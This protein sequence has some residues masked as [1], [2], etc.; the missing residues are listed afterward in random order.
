MATN[1]SSLPISSSFQDLVLESG[2]F[3][4]NATGSIITRVNVTASHADTASVLTGAIVSS[5]YS[6]S[7]SQADNAGSASVAVSASF[8]TSASYAV[9]ASVEITKEVSSSFADFAGEAYAVSGSGVV[10]A[11]AS[12]SFAETASL[13]LGSVES[14]SFASS[15]SVATLADSASNATRAVSASQ[16]DSASFATLAGDAEEIVIAVKSSQA[17]TILTGQT[18][19][20]VG[21]TGENVDV[22]TASNDI[23]A[24]MPAIGLAKEDI[25]PGSA[26]TAVIS[27]KILGVDTDG[28]TP[29]EVVYV[30]QN[31]GFTSTKPTGSALI[32][33]IGVVGKA[34]AVDGQLIVLGSGRSNDLPN[35]T[36]GYAWVG[37][38]NQVPTAVSTASFNAGSASFAESA[39]VATLAQTASNAINA[40][41]ASHTAG[42]ASF[43]DNASSASVAARATTL[44]SDA[45]ASFADRATSASIA[46]ELSQ[47]ATA[48][49]AITA[50]HALNVPATASH[51][52]T[53]VSASQA[54]NADS[55]SNALR[56]ITASIADDIKQDIDVVFNSGSF[57]NLTATTASI[58]FLQSITG[59]AKII[60]DAFII[61]NNDLPAERFAGIK[62]IDTG[63]TDATASLVWDGNT[64]DWKYD[65]SASG[66]ADS[67]VVLFGPHAD[68]ITDTRYPENN[69]ILKGTGTHH[70]ASS[71]I[72]DDATTITMG[73]TTTF[74]NGASGSFSGSFEG[75]ASSLTG[76]IS[77]SHAESSSVATFASY[78]S[79]ANRA[80][81]ADF[82]TS[83][84]IA[85]QLQ[86]GATASYAITG[87]FAQSEQDTTTNIEYGVVLKAIDDTGKLKTDLN[88]DN[89]GSF[90]YNPS[91]NRLMVDNLTVR[92]SLD[93]TIISSSYAV[94]ASHVTTAS[95]ADLASSARNADS[96]SNAINAAT[97]SNLNILNQPEVVISGSLL[98]SRSIAVEPGVLT[99]SSNTA[100]FDPEDSNYFE[101]TLVS[102]SNT[103]VV[104]TGIAG[105]SKGRTVNFKIT[106][107]VGSGSVTFDPA[108][109]VFPTGSIYTGSAVESTVDIVSFMQFNA[110]GTDSK[111]YG[112]AVTN[113][114]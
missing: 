111:F 79:V 44:S 29:G 92:T 7:S 1:I 106:Q 11:V 49:F 84:S 39:S 67:A 43:A 113:L 19:H 33:N 45:T 64:N 73:N 76:I 6:V 91:L 88:G 100:S 30:N 58:G 8:A 66:D 9:S 65:F 102:G 32:Q 38:E 101:L 97:A 3:L 110:A 68:S 10:G 51:A 16:A 107:P 108:W 15:A 53:A 56:A 62:V 22:I 52:L 99:I 55:A 83:A 72:S 40:I 46:D 41:T 86:G 114:Q 78:S 89:T 35:I 87:A 34:N 69:K 75:D 13:L 105:V 37:N 2:S 20:A 93:A 48:S 85:A 61:L 26:G 112:T 103:Q 54:E 63:S 4:Q 96:A 23:P 71:S 94:T 17:T 27:G 98:L 77:A 28:L 81:N 25:S 31:G 42:T 14:A 60:G 36:S 50:S 5:S 90:N 18:L 24:N 57:N 104:A 59:S 47:L 80:E 12:A 95:F 74:S 82:A 21:V 70:L 109:F